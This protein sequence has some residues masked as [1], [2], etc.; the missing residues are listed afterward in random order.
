MARRGTEL[1]TVIQAAE[2]LA[3]GESSVRI[4]CAEGRFPNARHYG[5]M[6]LIPETDL[7]GFVKRGIGRPSKQTSGQKAT[8]PAGKKVRKRAK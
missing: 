5:K 6:W 2:R 1:L 4:W 3:A 8:A 7:A